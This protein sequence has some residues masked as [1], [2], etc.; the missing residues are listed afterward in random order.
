MTSRPETDD[1]IPNEGVK[2]MIEMEKDGNYTIKQWS[3]ATNNVSF[4]NMIFEIFRNTDGHIQLVHWTEEELM[5][6]FGEM[7]EYWDNEE[8]WDQVMVGYTELNKT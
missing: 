8:F 1:E 6:M 5:E 4:D 2:I 3:D 7:K